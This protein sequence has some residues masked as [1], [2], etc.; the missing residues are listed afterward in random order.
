MLSQVFASYVE[1]CS[2]KMICP[3]LPEEQWGGSVP[4]GQLHQWDLEHNHCVVPGSTEPGHCPQVS[5]DTLALSKSHHLAELQSV[6]LPDAP[7]IQGAGTLSCSFVFP[8]EGEIIFFSRSHNRS[9]TQQGQ[10]RKKKKNQN[11]PRFQSLQTEMQLG[12][13]S[14][15]TSQYSLRVQELFILLLNPSQDR[16]HPQDEQLEYHKACLFLKL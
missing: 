15:W 9:V 14:P 11:Q 8:C 3:S 12:S 1:K 10:Q 4:A 7:W 2:H 13:G 5:L 6:H 16:E